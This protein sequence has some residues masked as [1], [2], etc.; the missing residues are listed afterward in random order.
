MSENLVYAPAKSIEDGGIGKQRACGILEPKR[1]KARGINNYATDS[2]ILCA[3]QL[4]LRWLNEG[5][6]TG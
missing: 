4:M 2:F 1:D 5:I 6:L 3:L